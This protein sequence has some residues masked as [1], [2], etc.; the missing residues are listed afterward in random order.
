MQENV[1]FMT[2]MDLNK[3]ILKLCPSFDLMIKAAMANLQEFPGIAR[4]MINPMFVAPL[5]PW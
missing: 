4:P 2:A 5:R 3:L 1:V